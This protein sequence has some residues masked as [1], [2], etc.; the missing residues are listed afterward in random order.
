VVLFGVFGGLGYAARAVENATGL[1][2][3]GVVTK[4]KKPAA[5]SGNTGS[6]VAAV[7]PA[8][9]QY[10][11]KT[12]ICHQTSSETNPFVVITVSNNAL[13]AHVAHGDTLVNPNPPPDCPGPPIVLP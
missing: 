13:P 9:A 1:D 2:V 7:T 11:G 5:P 10:E 3:P 6:Q 8:Q 4:A 12:T